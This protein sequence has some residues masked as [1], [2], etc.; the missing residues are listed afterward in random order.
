MSCGKIKRFYLKLAFQK[1]F[2]FFFSTFNIFEGIDGLRNFDGGV[3]CNSEG[4]DRSSG[5]RGTDIGVVLRNGS[6][7]RRHTFRCLESHRYCLSR[8]K[9]KKPRLWYAY[10][11]HRG[12]GP[13]SAVKAGTVPERDQGR[14]E[15]D[16]T[17][18]AVANK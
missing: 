9:S 15:N 3:S 10:V 4:I 1:I 6:H 17:F 18:E 12:S 13:A 14:N 16:Y 8:E 2:H 11:G 5:T 7:G